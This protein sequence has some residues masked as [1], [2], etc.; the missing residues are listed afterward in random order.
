MEWTR[1]KQWL[2][3]QTDDKPLAAEPAEFSI[4]LVE[5]GEVNLRRD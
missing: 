5:P 2:S 3:E 1:P 4:S